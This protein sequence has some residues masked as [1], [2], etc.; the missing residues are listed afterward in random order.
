VAGLRRL[1]LTMHLLGTRVFFPADALIGLVLIVW[2][3]SPVFETAEAN[4]WLLSIVFGVLLLL[5]VLVHEL[6]HAT[7]A[8][9]FGF[10]VK[11]ITI[12]ALGGVTRYRAVDNTPGRE[13][14]IAAVGPASTLALAGIAWAFLEVFDLRGTPVG[15]IL[16]S[17]I[18]AN[19]IIGLFN[20]LPGLPLDG[21]SLV[22]ALWWRITGSQGKG[23]VAGAWA[24]RVIAVVVMLVP[25]AQG[26]V[27]GDAPS[28]VYVLLSITVGAVLFNGANRS[29]R[30]ARAHMGVGVTR[31]GEIAEPIVVLSVTGTVADIPPS[32]WISLTAAGADEVETILIVDPAGGPA[33]A[34][35]P[36]AALAV[37]YDVRDQTPLVSVA[38]RLRTCVRMS[39]D[40]PARNAAVVLGTGGAVIV[41]KAESQM[42]VGVV[43]R[44]DEPVQPG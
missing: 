18:V 4:T 44:R 14:T 27:L 21:G 26:V 24:G 41:T 25:F 39:E 13:A 1:S 34:V 16:V 31:I 22:T 30:A 11:G 10:P 28:L 12:M 2:F 33:R 29:M 40:T 42:P 17:F 6:A 7:A 38:H 9:A 35:V 32:W 8:H 5:S 19:V 43:W 36:Q 20:L 3:W 23:V 37:P 15:L